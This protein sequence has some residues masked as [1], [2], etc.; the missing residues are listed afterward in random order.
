VTAMLLLLAAFAAGQYLETT[1]PFTPGTEPGEP[2]S[3]VWNSADNRVYVG[4]GDGLGTTVAVI[5]GATNA[6][7]T[8]AASG[9][10]VLALLYNPVQNRVY[11][12]SEYSDSLAIIDGASGAA[13]FLR[14]SFG[15][16]DIA[17]NPNNNAVYS[18]A[19]SDS[20]LDVID[21]VG[22]TVVA[23][24]A[25][26]YTPQ[27]VVCG[28]TVSKVYV[29]DWNDENL[30]VI[31]C[32]TN[33][34]VATIDLEGSAEAVCFNYQNH[35]AYCAL[36][37]DNVVK[38]VD[39]TSNA[40]VATVNVPGRPSDMVYNPRDNRIYVASYV[41][42]YV[43]V[44]DGATNAVV[45]S[46]ESGAGAGAI[47]IDTAAN[48]A[49][50]ANYDDST[51]TVID[52]ATLQA[53]TTIAVGRGPVAV[54]YNATSGR[55]YVVNQVDASVSV[56]R[57]GVAAVEEGTTPDSPLAT[58]AAT[59]VHGVLSV[60]SSSALLDVTGRKVLDLEPGPNDVS[61]LAP[62]VYSV[63]GASGGHKVLLAK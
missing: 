43:T 36:R 28:P 39:G 31:S 26:G 58:R 17:W 55:I 47:A 5:D 8:P 32:A 53:E 54:G 34:V 33:V 11:A 44:I 13:T 41:S 29:S 49:W 24:V 42:G 2:A 4:D 38:V 30:K 9:R 16:T 35:K 52:C 48:K 3:I 46:I 61:G 15:T 50:C 20:R 23:Q 27:H 6:K 40:V 1:I 60:P 51:V 45:A 37:M 18:L 59:I 21:C 25:L 19:Y 63:R 22:E 14:A 12:T 7:L 57:D 62:G 10:S 56:L